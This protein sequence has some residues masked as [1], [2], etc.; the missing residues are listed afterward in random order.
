[1]KN[2]YLNSLLCHGNTAFLLSFFFLPVHYLSL[3]NWWEI[4]FMFIIA[5]AKLLGGQIYYK[6]AFCHYIMSIFPSSCGHCRFGLDDCSDGTW[7][8]K[9][10]LKNEL[11]QDCVKAKGKEKQDW[12]KPTLGQV[13]GRWTLM[14]SVL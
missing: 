12:H 11:A 8:T 3:A 4:T 14:R 10:E 13:F 2:Y 6:T 9:V 5:S 7:Q 1:M